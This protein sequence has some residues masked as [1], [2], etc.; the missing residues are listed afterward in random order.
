[1]WKNYKFPIILVF[2]ILAGSV[3]GIILGEKADILSP[4]GDVFLN[5]M[6][7]A[8]VPLVFVTIAG[9]VSNMTNMKRLGKILGYMLLTFI[10]TGLIAAVV[11]IVSVKIFP[12]AK[13]VEIAL[14]TTEMEETASFARQVVKAITVSDFSDLLSRRNMLPLIIFSVMFGFCAGSLG[15]GNVVAVSLAAL[16]DVM[17]KLVSLI[18]MYAPIGLFAYFA[19]LIGQFGPQL[20]GAYGRAMILYY[21][22]CI[23]YFVIAF[24]AYAW[25]SRGK[26][27]VGA[28]F[29]N[30]LSPALTSLATQSSIAS[31]PTNM[32]A[33]EKIGVSKD[34]SGIVLPIGATMHMD[35]S[36]LAA[37]LKISFLYGIFGKDFAG[38][39]VYII[40][41]LIAIASGVVLSG[42]PGGGL[43]GEMLIVSLMGFPAQAF[44][45][46]ATIG[47]LVDPPATCLNVCGDTVCSMIVSRLIDGKDWMKKN[48]M[49]RSKA[50]T[51]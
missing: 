49:S 6:F 41:V 50:K 48:L 36:V 9:A 23:V 12:P 5:L 20:I 46:I 13:G 47:F 3:A 32:E 27:G 18:M 37:V 38:L 51:E 24:A 21:P 42:V 19:T 15:E 33:C 39:D 2:S 8:V 29:K 11:I 28:F 16:S 35:G 1:M 26:D 22:L 17:M 44:P 10:V 7:T 40:S 14:E 31:L 25:F 43:V 30:I 4:L 45:L 34:I